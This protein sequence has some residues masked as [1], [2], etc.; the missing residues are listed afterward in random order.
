MTTFE[1]ERRNVGKG[2]Q[3]LLDEADRK[4]RELVDTYTVLQIK[5]KFGG[6]RFYVSLPEYTDE[7]AATQ[8]WEIVQQAE[9][10]SLLVCEQCGEPAETKQL[11]GWLR[12]LCP[13]HR[14]EAIRRRRELFDEE[15]PGD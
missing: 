5:E 14:E 3:P 11:S 9:E 15:T 2:W 13:Q 6:L 12:T 7:T 8:V 10:A 1:Q 4:I